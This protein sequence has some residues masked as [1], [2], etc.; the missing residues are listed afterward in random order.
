MCVGGFVEISG[1]PSFPHPSQFLTLIPCPPPSILKLSTFRY[2]CKLLYLLSLTEVGKF[3]GEPFELN[4]MN[5]FSQRQSRSS[6][7]SAPR[8][9]ANPPP[10]SRGAHTTTAPYPSHTANPSQSPP[11][12]HQTTSTQTSSGPG[13]LAQMAATAGSVA[14]GSTIGHG[15]SHM[16]F[17]SGGGNSQPVE[18]G[19]PVQH[20]QQTYQ[21]SGISCEI[22]AKGLFLILD[23]PLS[24]QSAYFCFLQDF[25]KCLEAADA[26]TC[27]WFLEQLKAVSATFSDICWLRLTALSLLQCQAAASKY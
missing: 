13:M 10:Q 8:P 22:Q 11:V 12:P 24:L 5:P 1:P 15:L 20:Q 16:L 23:S 7:R 25:T 21:Q 3:G 2:A 26:N 27:S 18:Q 4:A 14:V 6:A 17:G 19:P 9:A